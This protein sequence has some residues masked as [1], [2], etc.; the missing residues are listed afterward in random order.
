MVFIDNW[1]TDDTFAVV[2]SL[3]ERFPGRIEIEPLSRRWPHLALRV[4]GDSQAQG[5]NRAELSGA[6]DS[7]YRRRR[8]QAVTVS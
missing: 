7:A 8:A 1:S 5:R 2:C 6:L 3:A 4:A